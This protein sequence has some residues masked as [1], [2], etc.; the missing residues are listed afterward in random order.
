MAKWSFVIDVARC[1]DCNNCFMAC[2][3]EF[4]ENEWPPY[5]SAQPRHGHRWM[6]V[7]RKEG[8]EYP[9]VEVAYLPKPCQHCAD[10][11][12]VTKSMD[13]AVY[14]REDGI[15]L[16]DPDKARGKKDIV[17]LCPYGAIYWND[18]KGVPQK[19]TLCVHLLEEGWKQPRCVQA[20]PTEALTVVRVEQ[21]ELD[22]MVEKEKLEAYHPEFK[23]KPT[24]LYKNLSLFTKGFVAGSVAIRDSDECAEGVNVTLIQ[25]P[26]RQIGVTTTD[27]YGDFKF[28][29]LAE[30]S[31]EYKVELE[32]PGYD[33]RSVSF[34]FKTSMNL[35]TLFL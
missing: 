34:D 20:C 32:A 12:C 3:D 33:T 10:A 2:K 1:H 35:G 16:I 19:C 22:Q 28:Q 25:V 13:G 31:G 23:T 30:G 21:T 24:T 27:N 6:N 11:A 14:K 17:D 26:D 29:G 18:E 9:K 15:V 8:G 4:V 5:S 7:M